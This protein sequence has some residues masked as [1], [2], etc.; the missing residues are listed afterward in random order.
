MIRLFRL[1]QSIYFWGKKMND[2]FFDLK[3]EKQDKMI[4]GAMRVFAANG[5]KLASTDDMVKVAGVSKGLWFHY[6][7]NKAGL[8]TFVA[9]YCVKYLNMELSVNLIGKTQDYFEILYTVEETKAQ[10]AKMYPYTPLMIQAMEKED[11]EEIKD[12]AIA[13][14]APFTQKVNEALD[15][16]SNERLKDDV[17]R[18]VLDKV[19]KYT[20]NG[21]REKAYSGTEFDSDKYL[22][23]IKEFFDMMKKVTYR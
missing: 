9:D 14:L 22:S 12:I 19:V 15:S 17:S 10:I 21:I 2:K 20:V 5:Y 18:E 6:F 1:N 11:D 16:F 8:Y 7:S 4:N 23:E 3:K 13:K